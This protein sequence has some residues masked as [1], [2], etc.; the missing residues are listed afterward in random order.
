[1]HEFFKQWSLILLLI[2]GCFVFHGAHLWLAGWLERNWF[3]LLA[4]AAVVAFFVASFLG[5]LKQRMAAV[6]AEIQSSEEL[7]GRA[8]ARDA[9]GLMAQW[10]AYKQ[11]GDLPPLQCSVSLVKEEVAC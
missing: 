4:V 1:M 10:N 8:W 11:A 5:Q 3:W 6:R 2:V 9:R 7:R